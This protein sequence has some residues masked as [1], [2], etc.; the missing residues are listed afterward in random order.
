MR[1]PAVVSAVIPRILLA[2]VALTVV[3]CNGDDIVNNHY[4]G[5]DGSRN[6]GDTG[7]RTGENHIEDCTPNPARVAAAEVC[8]ADDQCP[9]G[10]ACNN[11]VCTAQCTSNSACGSGQRCDTFGRCRDSSD[12]RTVAALSATTAG[13]LSVYPA[14]IEARGALDAFVVVHAEQNSFGEMRIAAE[15]GLEVSCD[16]GSS[17]VASCI[18]P[19][20]AAGA[21]LPI[22]IRTTSP[23]ATDE[24]RT[25]DVFA[26]SQ[27]ASVSIVSNRPTF[28]AL[29]AAT[30]PKPVGSYVGR[31]R[32][33][34]IGSKISRSPAE[35][36]G[37]KPSSTF[38]VEINAEVYANTAPSAVNGFYTLVVRD[39]TRTVLPTGQIIG[40]MKGNA[41]AGF[42]NVDFHSD[43]WVATSFESGANPLGNNPE[44]A[45]VRARYR[46]QTMDSNGVMTQ[47]AVA[48]ISVA[49]V[50]AGRLNFDL[51]TQY[52]VAARHQEAAKTR[53]NIAL[54]YVGDLPSGATVPAEPASTTA[55]APTLPLNRYFVPS[56]WEAR[57]ASAAPQTDART[58]ART[59]AQ[60]DT[61]LGACKVSPNGL[62]S[63]LS[64]ATFT[65]LAA[66][67]PMRLSQH[68]AN[69]LFI[70]DSA[71]NPSSIGAGPTLE[72]TMNA[73]RANVPVFYGAGVTPPLPPIPAVGF[74]NFSVNGLYNGD[75]TQGTPGQVTHVTSTGYFTTDT[76]MASFDSTLDGAGVNLSL[77]EVPCAYNVD[78]GTIVDFYTAFVSSQTI[79]RCDDIADRMGCE[80]R[81]LS[82]A[83]QSQP[84]AQLR[85]VY[86]SPIT[87]NGIYGPRSFTFTASAGDGSYRD[88]RATKVCRLPSTPLVCAELA[89]CHNGR[90]STSS[91][92]VGSDFRTSSGDAMC[93]S[94]D[95][96]FGISAD[97]SGNGQGAMQMLAS[98][99]ADSAKLLSPPA[100]GANVQTAYANNGCASMGG[101]LFAM[102]TAS[103]PL[104]QS[105]VA[106][107]S[108]PFITK[109]SQ[110]SH[111]LFVRFADIF[112]FI[113][114]ESAQ[115]EKFGQVVRREGLLANLPT[116]REALTA[117]LRGWSV[118]F[119][120][121]F[122]VAM[123]RIDAATLL[124]PDYRPIFG[125][126]P[127]SAPTGPRDPLSVALL[128]TITAQLELAD[129][130][131][132][133]AQP[134]GDMSAV[135]IA[136]EALRYAL[137]VEA[138][139]AD[140]LTKAKEGNG[141]VEPAWAYRHTAADAGYVA[142]RD[143]LQSD[144]SILINRSNPL[145][146]SEADLPLYFT[147]GQV[148]DDGR[149]FAISDYLIGQTAGAEQN[150]APSLINDAQNRLDQ[151][152]SAWVE[153]Q[154]RNVANSR[155]EAERDSRLGDIMTTYGNRVAQLCGTPISMLT[156]DVLTDWA[157]THGTPFNPNDCFINQQQ[158]GCNIPPAQ[159]IAA[160]TADDVKKTVCT[161]QEIDKVAP[162]QAR[163]NDEALTSSMLGC[164]SAN[165]SLEGCTGGA[166]ISCGGFQTAVQ[167]MFLQI[168]AD[169]SLPPAVVPAAKETCAT[170]FPNAAESPP[171]FSSLGIRPGN[172]CFR[173]DIGQQQI[174]VAAI[175]KDVDIARSTLGDA[176]ASYDI[177]IKSCIRRQT[178]DNDKIAMTEAHNS[179]MHKFRATKLAADI[180][181]NVAAGFKDCAAQ[182]ASAALPWDKGIA[183]TGCASAAVEAAAKSISDGMQFAMDEAEAEHGVALDR[184]EAQAAYDICKNDA[185]QYT[186]GIR[187]QGMRIQRAMLDLEAASTNL[188][189]LKAAAQRA[190]LDGQSALAA[191]QE[192]TLTPL[193]SDLWLD[194]RVEAFTKSMRVAK[195]ITYLAVRAVEYEYQQTL[196]ARG[197]VLAAETPDDLTDALREL[198]T[199]TGP[200]TVRG[201]KPSNKKAVLS[202][203]DAI[204][205]MADQRD[206]PE[207]SDH[208]L[209]STDRLRLILTSKQ[210]A[211]FAP[212]GT[213]LGQQVPF[214]VSPLGVGTNN[215]AAIEVYSQ[216][217]CAE[218]LWS[219][220]A[221]ILGGDL[222]RG[223]GATFT[224]LTVLKANT[225][226]SQWCDPANRDT[227]LQSAS[228]L[229]QRNLFRDSV[230]GSPDFIDAQLAGADTR[231]S[232]A[233]IQPS[234]N[235][236]R[237]QF[238]ND[239]F[240]NGD[241]SQLAAR[242]LYGE[243]ALF[244]PAQVLSRKNAN[245][246]ITSG[247]DLTHV[248]DILV[249][250]DYVTV[251]R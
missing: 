13:Q 6:D 144:V 120:P 45:N 240:E 52:D 186:V 90:A 16:G 54:T 190:W 41:P 213:Y 155:D 182:Q 11:G 9:C 5:G 194:E 14:Y 219:V 108:A 22:E 158:T 4:Y 248:D 80:V 92:T 104:R 70:F 203:R 208:R 192:R 162:G 195:R 123:Q 103:E 32:V 27:V 93:N 61:N 188:N 215:V 77:R 87:L 19:T 230:A 236:P 2:T 79:D 133:R 116:P 205:R 18:V 71:A 24:I 73:S 37:T 156:A 189:N 177:A 1:R 243:Y 191:E 48:D 15:A 85:Y 107:V 130:I 3:R 152:R 76:I 35:V 222:L 113:A 167:G 65:G 228:V 72:L 74:N 109:S 211:V 151:A 148:S 97:L 140:L 115:A 179:Q 238:E 33:R 47:P 38:D 64:A 207:L 51:L 67:F 50:A 26:G 101:L 110:L 229:P 206:L 193:D 142:A 200:R 42:Y 119:A 239:A 21:D 68:L 124:N 117:S 46:F 212:D 174:T 141:G 43:T 118:L 210:F 129:I 244:F 209:T 143:R 235:V 237:E 137:M 202:M 217:S 153:R 88:A 145:G 246:D 187:T 233:L 100:A 56:L 170:E 171:S 251:A 7:P 231:Y 198:R 23:I 147:G 122:Q 114:R 176:Q 49:D 34:D 204:L 83:E 180:A 44:Y 136:G 20:L 66:D 196:L 99:V 58:T 63:S 250:L 163:L 178:A 94:N 234:L 91:S 89:A 197:T 161:L 175:A 201:S 57:V 157:T 62:D 131:V 242:G 30:S 105:V 31:A 82:P 55:D 135:T 96:T 106:P 225:F 53:W 232:K 128:R 127:E 146:I 86:T 169:A 223:S 78:G 125:E 160:I 173:G 164:F 29:S 166:C 112:G 172:T 159:Y 8:R 132:T 216:D 134:S 60:V 25:V 154:A 241:S 95:A 181:S 221:S 138:S 185:S 218:K 10:T 139:A 245:G 224:N 75:Q 121:R 149:Y 98:C 165:A 247:L 150:W 214:T 199:Y 168:I 69:E 111:R 183:A 126:V 184:V 36:A 28:S 12:E 81:T 59:W 39:R 249:R 102:G 40:I 84:G 226:F 17:F 220:N 227:V